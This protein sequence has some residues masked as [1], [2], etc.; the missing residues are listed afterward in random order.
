M[1]N[2]Y[3]FPSFFSFAFFHTFFL[4]FFK[5]LIL[6]YSFFIL[7]SCVSFSFCIFFLYNLLYIQ[8]TFSIQRGNNWVLRGTSLSIQR[9]RVRERK[10]RTRETLV[11]GVHGGYTL[12][13]TNGKKKTELK[14]TLKDC[15]HLVTLY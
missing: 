2:I 4:Y 13:H 1:F 14:V 3:P 8:Y 7:S 5:S 15:I 10:W 9:Y 12:L 6:I 11:R